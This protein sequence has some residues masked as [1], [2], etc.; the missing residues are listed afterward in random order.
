MLFIH[1]RFFFIYIFSSSLPSSSSS[2][3]SLCGLVFVCILRHTFSLFFLL[4]FLLL[5]HC[6]EEAEEEEEEEKD[7]LQRYSPSSANAVRRISEL[8]L[9]KIFFSL[10]LLS[11]C[12]HHPI[13]IDIVWLSRLKKLQST[14]H[15]LFLIDRTTN[16]I[17]KK[18]EKETIY[19]NIYSTLVVYMMMWF[20]SQHTVTRFF[21]CIF[22]FVTLIIIY[23][24]I[25]HFI[26]IDYHYHFGCTST[27]FSIWWTI[28]GSYAMLPWLL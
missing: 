15:T 21:F 27:I 18:R 13:I 17:K 6:E 11:I 24:E 14:T 16:H 10:W 25:L 26:T 7:E 23:N 4:L 8:L 28:G 5:S 9:A 22:L 2:P 3:S 12:D 1:H 19:V 20:I